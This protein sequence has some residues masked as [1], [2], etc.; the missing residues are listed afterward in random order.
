MKTKL[1]Q[2]LQRKRGSD[3]EEEARASHDLK[4]EQQKTAYDRKKK[5]K[6]KK[7]KVGDEVLIQQPKTSVK[8]PW[9]PEG[10]QVSK[11]QGSKLTLQ[12]GEEIKVRAK[13][14]VKLVKERPK[15]LEI[16]PKRDELPA[17]K[18]K[19]NDVSKAGKEPA[20]NK[21]PELDLEVSWATIQAR[22]RH[23]ARRG[24]Q[25]QGEERRGDQGQ[26]EER[27]DDQG[28]DARRDDQGQQEERRGDRGQDAR[29]GDQGQEEGA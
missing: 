9:D 17:Q 5:A 13:N 14:N 20:R 24:D 22:A 19:F 23:G 29:R 3:K 2:N 7:L 6:E 18:K 26:E 21:S 12:R 1:P 8:S 28:Q 11:V 27:H 15:E 16:R 25:G 4:K 10:F